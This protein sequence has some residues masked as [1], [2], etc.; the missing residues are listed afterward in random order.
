MF[1][2]S[3]WS[4]FWQGRTIWCI[5]MD[6]IH[7]AAVGVER[8]LY[9][10]L[11]KGLARPPNWRRRQDVVHGELAWHQNGFHASELVRQDFATTGSS[12]RSLYFPINPKGDSSG[13]QKVFLA[14]EENLGFTQRQRA[15]PCAWCWGAAQST[16]ARPAGRPR[17]TGPPPPQVL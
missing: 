15:V 13:E 5:L 1:H 9:S 10:R 2:P 4:S 6:K 14:E 7:F 17:S 11:A 8:C 12:P 16:P 3:V